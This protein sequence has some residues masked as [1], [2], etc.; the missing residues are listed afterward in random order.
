MR[1]E[2]ADVIAFIYRDEVYHKDTTDKPGAAEVIIGKQRNGP[3]GH[4]ELRFEGRY[5]R[6]EN[7]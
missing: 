6:F 5:T 2:D 1:R 4:F 7:L 3:V